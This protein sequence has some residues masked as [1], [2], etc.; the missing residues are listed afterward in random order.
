[1]HRLRTKAEV[2]IQLT[3]VKSA[4]TCQASS[5]SCCEELGPGSRG[6]FLNQFPCD[7]DYQQGRRAASRDLQIP[8]T[9]V[10]R[11]TAGL[12]SPIGPLRGAG[13][14]ALSLT[15]FCSFSMVLSRCHRSFSISFFSLLNCS[16]CSVS[17]FSFSD[18]CFCSRVA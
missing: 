2:L 4:L 11:H 10:L 6:H 15:S 12:L 5:G 7:W 3:S 17:S 13:S 16:F 14:H 8:D 18:N 9:F 1:M